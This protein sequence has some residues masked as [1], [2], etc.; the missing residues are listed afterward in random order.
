MRLMLEP[1]NVKDTTVISVKLDMLIVNKIEFLVRK[2]YFRSK[3]DFIRQAIIMKLVR[4]G[5]LPES[6]LKVL[7]IRKSG[8]A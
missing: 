5:Y 3:S 1:K 2:G 6:A 8:G 7:G 4:D